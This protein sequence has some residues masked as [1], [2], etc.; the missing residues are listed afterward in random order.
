MILTLSGSADKKNFQEGIHF[1]VI[2]ENGI[3]SNQLSLSMYSTHRHFASN[4]LTSF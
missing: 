1:F 4:T 3:Y 2:K